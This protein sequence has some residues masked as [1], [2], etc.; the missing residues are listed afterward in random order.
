[1]AQSLMCF[2]SVHDPAFISL[3]QLYEYLANQS[4]FVMN[5]KGENLM[6]MGDVWRIIDPGPIVR[7]LPPQFA[8]SKFWK[9]FDERWRTS[10]KP[11]APPLRVLFNVQM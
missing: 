4:L 2:P 10:G 6:W 8:L 7:N 3:M 9:T 11:A 5:L 1:M